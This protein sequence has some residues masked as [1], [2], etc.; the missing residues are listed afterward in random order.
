M[1]SKHLSKSAANSTGKIS[2]W[3]RRHRHAKAN[4]AENTQV[5][6]KPPKYKSFKNHNSCKLHLLSFS[7][8]V[9]PDESPDKR[10]TSVVSSDGTIHEET[11]E[12]RDCALHSN[13]T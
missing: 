3:A 11:I 4:T 10:R 9:P 12:Y 7:T 13:L 6:D 8:N 5:D 1:H 2:R